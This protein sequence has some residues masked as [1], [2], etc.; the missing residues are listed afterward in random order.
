[1]TEIKLKINW[2]T[3][4]DGEILTP[5]ELNL[6]TEKRI[7][8]PLS[9]EICQIIADTMDV[10]AIIDKLSDQYGYCI[11]EFLISVNPVEE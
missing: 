10:D 7:T 11:N 6:P 2:D 4:C 8:I 9:A 1:M 3:E 5:E